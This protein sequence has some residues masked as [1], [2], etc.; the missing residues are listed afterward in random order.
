MDRPTCYSSSGEG[1]RENSGLA[2]ILGPGRQVI[3]HLSDITPKN[4]IEYKLYF[5]PFIWLKL[6]FPQK[7]L[8]SNV[9]LLI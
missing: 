2:F 4:T 9:R 6:V 3:N 7:V 5:W 1:E 8:K